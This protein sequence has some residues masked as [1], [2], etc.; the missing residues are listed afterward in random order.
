MLED[1]QEPCSL[2]SLLPL[3]WGQSHHQGHCPLCNPFATNAELWPQPFLLRL[4]RRSWGPLVIT[5]LPHPL[6]WSLIT[7]QTASTSLGCAASCQPTAIA[8]GQ[9]EQFYSGFSL[10]WDIPRFPRNTLNKKSYMSPVLIL[11][12]IP[13]EG[14]AVLPRTTEGQPTGKVRGITCEKERETKWQRRKMISI[15]K[16]F[17]L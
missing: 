10:M 7:S 12:S 1:T 16:S 13:A 17:A 5:L 2:V 4:H 6:L 15:F 11:L 8:V 3:A 9:L 14:R